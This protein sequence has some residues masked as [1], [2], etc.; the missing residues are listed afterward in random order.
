MFILFA[1]KN[2]LILRK[3]EPMTSRSVNAYEARFEFSPDWEGLARTAVFKSG[4][5]SR[6]VLLDESG[7]CVIPW[8]VLTVPNVALRVGVYGTRGGELVLPTVWESLGIVQEGVSAG[9][10]VQPPTPDVYHQ[11]LDELVETRE[12]TASHSAAAAE[13][14][15]QAATSAWAAE[16]FAGEAKAEANRAQTLTAKM[17]IIRDG[18][19]WTYDPERGE[20]VSTGLA[21]QGIQ[22]ETGEQ[23]QTGATPELT[24]GEVT[25]LGP[26]Q[27]ATAALTG[28]PENPVLSLGIPKGVPGKIADLDNPAHS[29][30]ETLGPA[31]VVST[32]MAT[33]KSRLRPVSEISLVQEGNGTPSLTNI[34]NITGWGSIALT[35]NGEVTVQTLPETVYGGSYN[36]VTGELIITHKMLSLAV[37]DMNLSETVPGWKNVFELEEYFPAGY[38][39]RTTCPSNYSKDIVPNMVGENRIVY[40]DISKAH[41][42][43]QSDWKVQYPDLICQFVLPLLEPKVIQLDP[44]T[45]TA[46]SGVNTLSSDCGDTSL[47]F[48]ADLKKYIDKK[49]AELAGGALNEM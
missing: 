23:G 17:P 27:S 21:A 24:I 12:I 26:D 33:A 22:G 31:A 7:Q 5:E 6:S 42:L 14:A 43:M 39:T 16:A 29:I 18:V 40:I 36:W 45:F 49:F 47:T 4:S 32:D 19:W 25:T 9:E 44:R 48:T 11:I 20:Y 28:T 3:R 30:T 13:N 1:N 34:R 2:M 10:T 15:A 38:T 46:L 37:A 8:E 41:N 35:H